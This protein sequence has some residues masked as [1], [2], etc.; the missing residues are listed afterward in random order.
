LLCE[1]LSRQ[2]L[3]ED[4]DRAEA[5]ARQAEFSE[6]VR[7]RYDELRAA[8]PGQDERDAPA[9]EARIFREAQE[10]VARECVAQQQAARDG[11]PTVRRTPWNQAVSLLLQAISAPLANERDSEFL[12]PDEPTADESALREYLCRVRKNAV[13]ETTKL[14]RELARLDG[15]GFGNRLA[16]M[17]L[18]EF[19]EE[20][21][22]VLPTLPPAS[23][24][25]AVDP[26][27]GIEP[28]PPARH[29]EDFRSVHW[30]GTDYTFTPTQAACARVLWRQW[31]NRT[32]EIGEDTILTDKEVDAEARRLL[33]VF[34]DRKQPNGYHPAWGKM[35]VAGTTKG[36]YRLN[37][38]QENL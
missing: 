19:P 13:E 31:E 12:M 33:D 3:Q 11:I 30:Y 16:E 6:A 28:L 20:M 24:R 32:P 2:V 38:P 14:S 25:L 21:A 36:A 8:G 5:E 29:S 4:R 7:K 1:L 10:Q 37:P 27:R 35:I 23:P 15:E 34:R 22:E 17:L 9:W 18:Q 26:D